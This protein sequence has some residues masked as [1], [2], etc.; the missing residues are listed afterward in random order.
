MCFGYPKQGSKANFMSGEVTKLGLS[1]WL[2]WDLDANI[3]PSFPTAQRLLVLIMCLYGLVNASEG[4]HRS[5]K[6][7]S[8]N[9]QVELQVVVSHLLWILGTKLR[10]SRRAMCI[11]NSWAICPA[12]WCAFSYKSLLCASTTGNDAE[13]GT[14]LRGSS[15][16]YH[17][18]P[19][20][21]PTVFFFFK[22]F[23]VRCVCVCVFDTGFSV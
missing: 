4:A 19:L 9:L 17:V 14:F 7:V 15:R 12:S 2:G 22:T 11:L 20:S 13:F 16:Q 8:D 10:S 21:L 1:I 23:A 3:L 6:R 5:Q 18:L